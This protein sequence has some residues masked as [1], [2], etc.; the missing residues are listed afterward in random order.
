LRGSAIR[1]RRPRVI[2][3]CRKRQGIPSR[4]DFT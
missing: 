1:K 4:G 3:R 2:G